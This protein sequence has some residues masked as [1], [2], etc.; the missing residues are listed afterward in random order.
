[1]SKI[2]PEGA[3]A[4][5]RLKPQVSLASTAYLRHPRTFRVSGDAL[6]YPGP[7]GSWTNLDLQA[8]C[9]GAAGRASLSETSRSPRLRRNC[10][11]PGR[12]F[13]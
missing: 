8:A 11:P 1:M 3:R 10:R 6:C 9:R 7:T 13:G 4:R 12:E 5:P 2:S